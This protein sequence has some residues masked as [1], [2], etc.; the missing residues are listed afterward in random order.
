MNRARISRMVTL[1]VVVVALAGRGV[2]SGSALADAP[3][4]GLTREG[5]LTIV[6]PYA[7]TKPVTHG[8]GNTIFSVSVP[9]DATC[10]GDST[11]DQWRVT[12][13]MVPS[14]DSMD[15]VQ[16]TAF[17]PGPEEPG[18]YPL[19]G[20]DTNPV[21]E[22]FLQRNDVAGQ[23]GL[24]LPFAPMSFVFL[25]GQTVPNGTYRVGVA[26]TVF[27][28]PAMYWDTQIVVTTSSTKADD[29]RWRL[30]TVP[31]S[32]NQPKHRSSWPTVLV[33]FALVAA[34]VIWLL[35]RRRSPRNPPSRPGN[36]SQSGDPRPEDRHLL[37]ESS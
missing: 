7:Q 13:F 22:Q 12:T 9:A 32:V 35:V 26:C 29:F 16:F 24:I 28:R 6:E 18:R 10:P 15:T 36:P 17:G 2:G 19:V 1:G 4:P 11:N 33:F 8:D 20:L 31:E 25:D 23:P 34:A 27:D 30:T 14:T 5:G 37:K 21:V 3:P